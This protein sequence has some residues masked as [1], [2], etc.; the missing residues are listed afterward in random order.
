MERP[1]N[2]FLPTLGVLD[3]CSGANNGNE[4]GIKV[5]CQTIRKF[6]LNYKRKRSMTRSGRPSKMT[7]CKL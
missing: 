5:S 6:L 7:F 1:G 2:F 4:Y 3:K